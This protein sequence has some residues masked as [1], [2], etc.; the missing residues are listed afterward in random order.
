MIAYSPLAGELGQAA[1]LPQSTTSQ[2][3]KLITLTLTVTHLW[4]T[5]IKGS[6]VNIYS[7]CKYTFHILH[8][9]VVVTSHRSPIINAPLIKALLQA[10]ILLTRVAILNCKGHQR[11]SGPIAD[12]IPFQTKLLKKQPISSS[13][14]QGGQ[15]FALSSVISAN[16]LSE[17][18]QYQDL[19]TK[20]GWV[21]KP[22]QISLSCFQGLC[23]SFFFS[24]QF[25]HKL[26]TSN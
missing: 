25:S 18:Q 23:H 24:W 14:S 20:D 10:T 4:P 8:N 2:Q 16:S 9:H 1:A 12:G 19:L 13:M 15:H 21:P 3:A 7:D 11:P 22:G 5:Y 17:G 26:Q 6:Q